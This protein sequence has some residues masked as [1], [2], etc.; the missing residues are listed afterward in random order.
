MLMLVKDV[1]VERKSKETIDGKCMGPEAGLPSWGQPADGGD[2][3]WVGFKVCS[4][5]SDSMMF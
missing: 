2:R 4:N 5:L 3:G 1:N